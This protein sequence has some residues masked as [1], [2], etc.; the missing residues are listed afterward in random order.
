M[1]FRGADYPGSTLLEQTS[2]GSVT[3]KA[4]D[5]Y[6][7]AEV[8]RWNRVDNVI[9]PLYDLFEL[10]NPRDDMFAQGWNSVDGASCSGGETLDGVEYHHV[11][12]VNV[13]STANYLVAARELSTVW[14]LAHDGSGPQAR[15]DDSPNTTTITTA[16]TSTTTTP[17]P[18][19]L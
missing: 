14:S 10:A 6:F 18:L 13:G 12:S 3:T 17:T 9:E 19:L 16:A 1:R 7:G 11:S 8:V 4:Q 2:P 15:R 5:T